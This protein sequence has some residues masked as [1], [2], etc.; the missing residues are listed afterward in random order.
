MGLPAATRHP[1][2]QFLRLRGDQRPGLGARPLSGPRLPAGTRPSPI[3]DY[4]LIGDG[5]TA[6]L[7][8]RRGSID[9][10]CW[11]R[12]DSPACLAGLLGTAGH[13]SWHLAPAEAGPS[14][15]RRYLPGTLVL[16]TVFATPEGEVAV[17]DFMPVGQQGSH[18]VRVVE[19]RKG[20]VA[21]DMRLW[22]RFDYGATIPWVSRLATGAVQAVAG[23]NRV[24]LR[25][26]VPLSGESLSTHAAFAVAAG[27]RLAFTLS[28]SASHEA[29]PVP[30]DAGAALAATRGFWRD[31]HRTSRAQGR[32]GEVAGRSLITLKAL[33]F[34]PTGG[35]V[36]AP[37][38]SLPEWPGGARN[39]D[40]RYCWLR[41]SALT[42]LALMRGGH[43]TEAQ[44]WVDWLHRAVAG[45][46][47]QV[48]PLYGLSGERRLAEW[49]AEW[50]PGYHGARP[51]RIGNAAHG[52]MQLDVY[53]EVAETLW[54]ARLGGLRLSPASWGVQRA[55]TNHLA[56]IWREPDEGIWEVR[57]PRRAFTHSRV[58]AWVAFDRA[59]RRAERFRLPAPLARWRQAR[60]EIHAEVCAR[61]FHPGRN[62]F[63]QSYGAEVLD[64]AVLM[65]PLMGFLPAEDARVRGTVAAIERDLL[66]D[67]FVR[68]YDTAAGADGLPPGEGAF[69]AC[70]FWLA[71]TYAAMGRLDEAEALF[72]RLCGACND[73]G[74]L[75][76]E[77]D[78]A[79][80]RLLGNFPQAFSHVGLVNT[81]L[82]LARAGAGKPRRAAAQGATTPGEDVP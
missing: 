58:M 42:L 35:I 16:E 11:P 48:Q 52:Q 26:S 49:E 6:A 61:G 8:S 69:L 18:V 40:Y 23:P 24:V 29:L 79:G 17:L 13:G 77:Y 4:G 54:Q 62:A 5:T 39:W 21:M 78:P 12:F 28:W 33:I 64:A 47:T 75:A 20:R 19:G 81:A 9:W 73:L 41:D 32:T 30:L 56:V 2:R 71:D 3:G 44:A 45:T 43:F 27:E 65:M 59:I 31:W 76:E 50:L 25:A 14:V 63:T 36:A 46:P 1:G 37:T 34:A 51:V 57:G 67:G 70:S 66:H 68:R 80:G 10:L 15:R 82:G 60:D 53:G 55:F 7:V 74:L 38:T 72:A 22:L